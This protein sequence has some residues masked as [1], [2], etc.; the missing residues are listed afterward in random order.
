MVHDLYKS[1]CINKGEWLEGIY[2]SWKK[3]ISFIY[4][5]SEECISQRKSKRFDD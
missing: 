3:F 1:L 5:C 4:A 2:R